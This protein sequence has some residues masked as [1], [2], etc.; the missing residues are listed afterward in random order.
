MNVRTKISL[1]A[2]FVIASLGTAIVYSTGWSIKPYWVVLSVL[3]VVSVILAA[4]V[5]VHTRFKA[6]SVVLILAGL[7]AGQWWFVESLVMQAW[8]TLRGFAP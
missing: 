1:W 5:L 3:G 4:R 8:W 6:W 7:V 2:P